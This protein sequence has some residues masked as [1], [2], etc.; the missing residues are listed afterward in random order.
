MESTELTGCFDLAMNLS[1][2]TSEE[3][4][5][6]VK[7]GDGSSS[8][9][10]FSLKSAIEVCILGT[11]DARND[12][13]SKAFNIESFCFASSILWLTVVA[14]DRDDLECVGS[15]SSRI[16]RIFS[17]NGRQNRWIEK[18]KVLPTGDSFG[19]RL[20]SSH[21]R[22]AIFSSKGSRRLNFAVYVEYIKRE[23]CQ[24]FACRGQGASAHK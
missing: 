3:L 23:R 24:Q 10:S 11:I 19:S 2:M 22:T 14:L 21:F 12:D 13:S 9:S 8:S 17:D 6:E 1:R 20:P 15:T 7:A 16:S 4:K 18:R 5:V